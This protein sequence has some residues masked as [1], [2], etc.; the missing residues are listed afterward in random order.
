MS[1]YR[2]EL[3]NED[4]PSRA[5]NPTEFVLH[6]ALAVMLTSLHA[7]MDVTTIFNISQNFLQEFEVLPVDTNW[8]SLPYPELLQ[9]LIEI[10]S[11]IEKTLDGLNAISLY[12]RFHYR[13]SHDVPTTIRA[14][15]IL[16]EAGIDINYACFEACT[17]SMY[18]RYQNVWFEW[19]QALEHNGKRIDDVLD[20]EGTSWMLEDNWRDV[21]KERQYPHWENP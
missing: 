17:P 2:D 11:P 13:S 14:L 15:S 7:I 16:I 1:Y 8:S 4:V 6:V 9:V 18:A 19:G 10:G 5:A 21:W 3:L 20:M 12:M